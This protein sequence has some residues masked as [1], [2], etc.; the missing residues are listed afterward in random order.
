MYSQSQGWHLSRS[1]IMLNVKM[2]FL[3]FP[4]F[5]GTHSW[6][7]DFYDNVGMNNITSKSYFRFYLQGTDCTDFPW[8]MIGWHPLHQQDLYNMYEYIPYLKRIK[9]VHFT[10]R[11]K[12]GSIFIKSTSRVDSLFFRLLSP[13]TWSYFL[14]CFEVGVDLKLSVRS[15][16]L[17]SLALC[18][19]LQ[20]QWSSFI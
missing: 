16:L 6:T 10:A 7:C 13:Q 17:K 4:M 2:P 14:R 20:G 19:W 9:F 15:A 8:R 11:G 12:D 18:W 1:L 3:Y 5:T